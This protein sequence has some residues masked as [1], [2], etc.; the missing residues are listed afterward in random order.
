MT[1]YIGHRPS[2]AS[3]PQV[4]QVEEVWL[5]AV[6]GRAAG[7]RLSYGCGRAVVKA[8]ST[9]LLPVRSMPTFVNQLAESMNQRVLVQ[10]ASASVARHLERPGSV[11]T[12]SLRPFRSLC[13]I[14]PKQH[15]CIRIKHSSD[16]DIVAY[17]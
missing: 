1:I 13:R 2:I 11:Y 12:G 4:E 9:A 15:L 17:Q 7:L 10:S 3:R 8:A 16:L 5:C 14:T 6:V